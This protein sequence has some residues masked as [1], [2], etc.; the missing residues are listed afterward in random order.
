M[1]K[2]EAKEMTETI[3][4]IAKDQERLKELESQVEQKD[5]VIADMLEALKSIKANIEEL[6]GDFWWID[7]PDRGGF[8]CEIIE[9]AIAKA[10]VSSHGT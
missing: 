1:N 6:T 3:K 5:A 7:V 2:D 10:E 9:K 4:H 8:N